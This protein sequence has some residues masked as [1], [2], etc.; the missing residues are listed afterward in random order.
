M[1]DVQIPQVMRE[2][3]TRGVWVIQ[4]W[5]PDRGLELE[6]RGPS[7][8]AR[9]QVAASRL[10]RKRGRER[11]WSPVGSFLPPVLGE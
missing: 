8:P 3:V 7:W 10:L 9:A 6:R 2:F 5:E 1:P 11:G 4:E